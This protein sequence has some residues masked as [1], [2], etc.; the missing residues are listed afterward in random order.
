MQNDYGRLIDY[1]KNQIPDLDTKYTYYFEKNGSRAYI[2]FKSYKTG[3]IYSKQVY[4]Y[5]A[6]ISRMNVDAFIK[7]E[8][9]A[10]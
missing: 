6:W 8:L 1:I 9:E 5:P 3:K 2:K 7:N 10:D 4:E